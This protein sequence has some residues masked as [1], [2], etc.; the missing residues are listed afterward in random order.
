M[1]DR[2]GGV[3][4]E[5]SLVRTAYYPEHV[6]AGQLVPAAIRSDDLNRRG[7]SVDRECLLEIDVL[8]ARAAFQMA[9]QPNGRLEAYASVFGCGEVRREVLAEDGASAF[10]V[11]Y[12][13]V[14]G[15]KAHSCIYSA[16]PRAPSLVKA[17]KAVLLQ[18][19]NKRLTPLSTYVDVSQ[20]SASERGTSPSMYLD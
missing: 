2:A 13:P 16:I 20:T 14:E 12:E 15:N 8:K 18:H 11:L 9:Q 10:K 5:E 19:L 17:L 7:F 6:V 4:D 3:G 1:D